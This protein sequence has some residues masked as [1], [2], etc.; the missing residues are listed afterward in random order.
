MKEADILTW[1]LLSQLTMSRLTKPHTQTVTQTLPPLP[2]KYSLFP[3][4]RT[5]MLA[6]YSHTFLYA[7][8]DLSF[9][10]HQFGIPRGDRGTVVRE[11]P[12]G[13]APRG[14]AAESKSNTPDEDGLAPTPAAA[15]GE[16]LKACSAFVRA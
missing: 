12:L 4:A 11:L 6:E 13:N 16:I 7:Q 8:K 15:P 9:R 2:Q 5:A 10:C 14:V 1:H 3:H